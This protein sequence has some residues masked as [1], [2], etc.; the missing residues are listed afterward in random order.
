MAYCIVIGFVPVAG[1]FSSFLFAIDVVR[2]A[3]V[4]GE[5]VVVGD[6]AVAAI[7]DVPNAA[8][9]AT[10]VSDAGGV[11]VAEDIVNTAIP[12]P[13]SVAMMKNPAAVQLSAV[14]HDTDFKSE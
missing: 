11:G 12:G 5:I 2:T 1:I 8:G 3:V 14:A 6:G 4:F 10:S 7:G 13:K 9:G